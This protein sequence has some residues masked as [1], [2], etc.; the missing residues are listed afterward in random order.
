MQ[1]PCAI[2]SVGCRRRVDKTGQGLQRPR[3]VRRRLVNITRALPAVRSLVPP[4]TALFVLLSFLSTPGYGQHSD[5]LAVAGHDPN[6]PGCQEFL[7]SFGGDKGR[8]AGPGGGV[9]EDA[10]DLGLGT[11]G[12]PDEVPSFAP[13]PSELATTAGDYGAVPSMIGDFFG[14]GYQLGPA[15]GPAEGAYVARAGGDRNF[16]LAENNSPFPTDRVYFNYNHFANPL[17][18]TSGR[19][20]DLDRYTFGLEKTFWNENASLELRMPLVGGLDSTQFLGG[21]DTL[22]T[23][24]GNLAL[25][26]KG[27]ILAVPTSRWPADWPSFSRP[28]PTRRLS[29]AARHFWNSRTNRCTWNPSSVPTGRRTIGCSTSSCSSSTLTPTAAT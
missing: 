15:F 27:L 21:N 11:E 25:A 10:T 13:L 17:I 22:G 18:D 29:A 16:K 12:S 28:V 14:H 24:F 4:V 6:C 7:T 3:V 26:V 20:Q 8:S 19:S 1:Q 2:G 23:E 9:R 5:G